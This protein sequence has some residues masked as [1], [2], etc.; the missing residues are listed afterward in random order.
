MNARLAFRGALRATA[1]DGSIYL[2]DVF[3]IVNNNSH[4]GF[5]GLVIYRTPDGKRVKRIRNGVY[6]VESN[7]VILRL[8]DHNSSGKTQAPPMGVASSYAYAHYDSIAE[9]ASMSPETIRLFCRAA[10]LR[11]EGEALR[12]TSAERM[13]VLRE[14]CQRLMTLKRELEEWWRRS[15]VSLSRSG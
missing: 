4:D 1:E 15:R 3:E 2:I 10:V 11:K 5:G 7:R 8:V 13:G 12:R 9:S 14:H 6:E